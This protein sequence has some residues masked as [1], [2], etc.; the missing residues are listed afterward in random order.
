VVIKTKTGALGVNRELLIPDAEIG[1]GRDVV[2]AY[3]GTISNSGD[4]E[5][6]VRLESLG[7]WLQAAL[8][9]GDVTTA[10]GVSTATFVP[11]DAS[12]LPFLSIE[13]QVGNV[14]DCFQYTDAVVNT[15]H[16]ESD[17]GGYLSGTVGIIA[18]TR[19]SG[20]TPTVIDDQTDD[21][22]LLVGTN[23]T[24]TYNGVKLPAKSFSFDINNNIEDTDFRL[25]S[26]FLNDLT[27]KRREVTAS[28]GIRE[29]DKALWRQAALGTSTAVAPTGV[30]TKQQL[31]ITANTYE[32]AGGA[33]VGSLEIT[34]PQFAWKPYN[35]TA[36]GDD[37]LESTLEGQGIRPVAANPL[38]TVVVVSASADI[39]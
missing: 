8:G 3:L 24:A 25:G 38:M 30:P 2:D 35:I 22:P 26:F 21:S 9:T 1:G 34:I 37:I 11:S 18:K 10:A 4:Y 31:V 7:T 15:L 27:P 28:F 5:F 17:A 36:S 14:F 32:F 23:I 29:T 20:A 33:I 19:V 39:A 6:Y 13:E 16:M 12:Q